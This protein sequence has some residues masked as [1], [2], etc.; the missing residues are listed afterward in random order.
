[1]GGGSDRAQDGEPSA[2]RDDKDD[3]HGLLAALDD[4]EIDQPTSHRLS[5]ASSPDQP[6]HQD[7]EGVAGDVDQIALADILASEQPDP[8]HASSVEI[9][10][11]KDRSTISARSGIA[12]LPIPEPGGC[13]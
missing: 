10:G 2:G 12:C 6:P 11:A 3:R 9:V 4:E 8:P 7:A 5:W 13:G 1:M